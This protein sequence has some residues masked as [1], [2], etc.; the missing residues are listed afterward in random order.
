[1]EWITVLKI[2]L[3]IFKGK[4]KGLALLPDTV[5]RK[6]AE[7]KEYLKYLVFSSFKVIIAATS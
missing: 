2:A 7:L 1:M 6:E 5:E 4:I 3:D